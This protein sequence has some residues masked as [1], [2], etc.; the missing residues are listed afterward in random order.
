MADSVLVNHM[1]TGADF[2]SAAASRLVFRWGR[3]IPSD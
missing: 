2:M 3:R 1:L